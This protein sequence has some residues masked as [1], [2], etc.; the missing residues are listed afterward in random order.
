MKP[1]NVR[2]HLFTALALATAVG[3]PSVTAQSEEPRMA[4]EEVVV[5]ARRK[6]ES[7]QSVPIAVTAI[8]GASF[9]ASG[10]ADISELQ[11]QV[12]NLSIY[13]GRNQ[14]TTLTAFMR[15]V[16][17][18]DPLWGVDPGVGLYVDDVYIA[19][20]QGA[21][22][23]TFDVERIEVL[24][25]PQGTLYG[26]NTI[27]GAI[28]YVTRRPTDEFQANVSATFGEYSTQEFKAGISGPI[29][30]GKLRGKLSLA[31]LQRDGWG[32]NRFT[33]RDVSDKD[34]QVAIA[35]LEWQPNDNWL[36]SVGAD[37]TEDDAE[38]KG[39]KRL[40]ANPLCPFYG[41]TCEPLSD[42]YDVEAGHDPENN[43]ESW[44][45]SITISGTLGEA[46]GF[47]SITAY[48][49]NDTV[50]N[51]DFDTTSA[52]ITD[53]FADYTD[54]QFSQEFQFSYDNADNF[55]AVMGIYYFD[56]EAGG[57]VRNVFLADIEPLVAPAFGTTEGTTY[58]ES[59]AVFGE[60][61]YRATEKLT[62]TLGLRYTEE[63]KRGVAYNALW[64]DDTFTDVALVSADYDKKEDFPATS[65]RF[66]VRYEFSDDVMAFF[67][68][69]RG[70]KSGGFNVRAQ[71]EF[72]PESAEPFD[73]EQL[74]MYELGLK[75]TLADGQLRLNGTL[76]Y[77]DYEDVQV[78]TF[79]SYDSDGDGRDDAFFGNF[80]NA[81]S[82]ELSGVELE[83]AWY[84]ADIPWFS[85]TA[86]LNYLDTDE[87]EVDQNGDGFPDTR[88]ITNAPELT[89]AV[90]ANF[91]FDLGGA[92]LNGYLGVSYRDESILTNEG[93]PN[94][95]D[96]TQELLPLIQESYE[97]WNAGVA[98]LPESRNWRVAVNVRNLA[99]EEYLQTG[100]NIPVLGIV[101][102]SYGPPRMA[103]ASFEYF[104]D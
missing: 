29:V 99:D 3:S 68:A 51:I 87:D 82:A 80:L 103:T 100:Y 66:G 104:F 98:Y 96:P 78:S 26:K 56:G 62:L 1:S 12:P 39:Y 97:V 64:T 55:D 88:V 86:N 44:G 20:P 65:P 58:T 31:S 27:G 81:G 5:T 8:D 11:G 61:N 38:P 6:E 41:I 25:G 75:S 18:A 16:G 91:D 83:T 35:G 2:K 32:K 102:G 40:E 36:V 9:E 49:E 7:L 15:G 79:T 77:G 45:G 52:R 10:A 43:T 95:N 53:V 19:R 85:I 69:S 47:K 46:W 14:S 84:P 57:L 21:L 70:F 59:W 48:R 50:N 23:S 73:D 90:Q 89:G 54:D 76:F 63:E 4:L 71:S 34:T 37:Y 13:A 74:D 101:T 33:G 72:F 22:L 93:G 30:E 60:G 28:K 67:T 92:S 42:N 94:P 24:R 17:Q